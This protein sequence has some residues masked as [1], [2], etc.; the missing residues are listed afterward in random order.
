MY[1]EERR[2]VGVTPFVHGDADTV[3]ID[4]VLAGGGF[5]ARVGMF[6][7]GIAEPAVVSARHGVEGTSRC[8]RRSHLCRDV[9]ARGAASGSA[10][11]VP[12]RVRSICSMQRPDRT[13][14][15][16][17]IAVLVVAG[18]ACGTTDPASQERLPP[19][20][21]TTPSTTTT[22]TSVLPQDVVYVVQTR[23]LA[24]RRSPI[25]SASP[26]ARCMERN[27]LADDAIQAG[28]ELEIPAA[29]VISRRRCHGALT[30]PRRRQREQQRRFRALSLT[31][32]SAGLGIAQVCDSPWS[33]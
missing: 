1:C 4:V 29:M 7:C 16:S 26:S 19:I 2:C 17:G 11:R 25:A 18:A 31:W 15:L 13:I 20:V 22:T 3:R 28:Q 8:R 32:R 14:V 10:C 9:P 5:G 27:G 23:R 33:R 12:A 30:V 21:T 6:S 24:R